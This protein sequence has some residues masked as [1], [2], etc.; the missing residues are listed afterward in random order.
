MMKNRSMKNLLS[1][2]RALV[3]RRV[4][5]STPFARAH[6]L[7]G[8]TAVEIA[9]VATVIA[10]IALLALPIFRQRT[11]EAR[12]SAVFDEL[13]SL[14]KV[15][16]LAE[17]DTGFQVRLQDLSKPK[18]DGSSPVTIRT[19]D[20]EPI[21][22]NNLE[23]NWQGP[24][25]ALNSRNSVP[26]DDLQDFWYSNFDGNGF[27]VVVSNNGL[28]ARPP[29]GT[30]SP[31]NTA[32]ERYPIDPWG[33]PYVFFG[34]GNLP[35]RFAGG[36]VSNESNFNTSILVS[37]GPDGNVGNL[38]DDIQANPNAY[39]RWNGVNTGQIGNPAFDVDS[40]NTVGDFVYRF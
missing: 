21:N 34:E 16:L 15:Q 25:I 39:R 23:S 40:T 1:A 8:F 2:A 18:L 32:E 31:D 26:V 12:E 33:N 13:S 5:L 9:M 10:I 11:E 6:R 37:F 29:Q 30:E 28:A 19:W 24:Y 36:S 35:I 3:R 17:A 14:A 22:T 20:G 7:R 38:P 27:I 4:S